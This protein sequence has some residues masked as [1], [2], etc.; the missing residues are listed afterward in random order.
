[1]ICLIA[2]LLY[3][4]K[5]NETSKATYPKLPIVN[6]NEYK[7]GNDFS[8]SDQITRDNNYWNLFYHLQCFEGKMNIKPIINSNAIKKGFRPLFIYNFDKFFVNNFEI[9]IA[10]KFLTNNSNVSFRISERNSLRSYDISLLNYEFD[11]KV[12]IVSSYSDQIDNLVNTTSK[13]EI[14]SNNLV[15]NINSSQLTY[16]TVRKLDNTLFLG[17][18]GYQITTVP[19][20]SNFDYS[21]FNF[22]PFS[23]SISIDDIKIY[24]ISSNGETSTYSSN[25]ESSKSSVPTSTVKQEN[26]ENDNLKKISSFIQSNPIIIIVSFIAMIIGLISSIKALI[27]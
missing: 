22:I 20:K 5:Q 21:T 13:A 8:S 3:A 26:S 19:I 15:Y 27:K 18:N 14:T 10:S 11:G 24:R 6:Y 12:Q 25:I 4:C 23:G 1:M 7:Y 17:L 16:L 2:F 9:I